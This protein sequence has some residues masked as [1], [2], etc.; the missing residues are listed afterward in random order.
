[1]DQAS[2]LPP[3]FFENKYGGKPGRPWRYSTLMLITLAI[4]FIIAIITCILLLRTEEK[5]IFTDRNT[6][7]NLDLLR[8]ENDG[9]TECCVRPG[10][11]APTRAYI[12]DTVDDITYSRD[13]PNNIN[14]VCAGFPDVNQCINDNTDSEGNIVPIITYESIPYFT[15]EKGLFIGC[16]STTTC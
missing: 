11:T 8:D 13:R 2:A 5:I 14:V 3:T 10:Q 9:D 16:A 7:F 12:Y 15:F 1:M 6:L 4:I